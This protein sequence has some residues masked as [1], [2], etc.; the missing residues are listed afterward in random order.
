MIF[1]LN[2]T[3]RADLAGRIYYLSSVARRTPPPCL[4][5][6]V[7]WIKD[8]YASLNWYASTCLCACYNLLK[9]VW[10]YWVQGFTLSEMER[11]DFKIKEEDAHRLRD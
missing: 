11:L 5:H 2:Q 6:T 8:T 7:S 4:R 1:T 10:V 9:G 3:Q